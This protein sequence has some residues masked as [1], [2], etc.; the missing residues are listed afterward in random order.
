MTQFGYRKLKFAVPAICAAMTI[1]AHSQT[2][3]TLVAFDGNNGNDPRL[4]SPVQGRDGKIYGTTAEGGRHN[5][6]VLFRVS[7]SGAERVLDFCQKTGCP[8]GVYPEAGLVLGTDGN[9]Y[10]T[11]GACDGY[12]WWNHISS[13]AYGKNNAPA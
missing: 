4:M 3:N 8:V 12:L 2:F 9:F 5:V 7:R 13:N 10:G 6:G 1:L 11:T